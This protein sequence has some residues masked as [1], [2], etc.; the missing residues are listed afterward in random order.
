MGEKKSDEQKQAKPPDQEKSKAIEPKV[1][2]RSDV[3][4][5]YSFRDMEREFERMMDVLSATF[6]I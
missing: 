1:A 3:L 2:E 4:A 5:P 6:R